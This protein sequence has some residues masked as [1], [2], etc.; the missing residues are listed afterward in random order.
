MAEVIVYSTN[1]CVEC[2][3]VKRM[4]TEYDIAFEERNIVESIKYQKEV[5]SLGI[6]G[7][8]VTIYKEEAVKGMTP[9]LQTLVERIQEEKNSG[10]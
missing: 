1:D 5:E 8:P 2:G 4:L 6:M 3:I 7:V 10:R 9:E